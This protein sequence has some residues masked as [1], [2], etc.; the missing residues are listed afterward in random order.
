MQKIFISI[1]KIPCGPARGMLS[2]GRFYAMVNKMGGN[3]RLN[4]IDALNLQSKPHL[5]EDSRLIA[6]NSEKAFFGKL[7]KMFVN[8]PVYNEISFPIK[9]QKHGFG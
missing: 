8:Q 2:V 6:Q 1:K 7:K 5:W 9:M 4:V 3:S